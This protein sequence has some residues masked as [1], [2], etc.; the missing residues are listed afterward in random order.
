MI[1]QQVLLVAVAVTA[2]AGSGTYAGYNMMHDADMP[3]ADMEG[4][5]GMMGSMHGMDHDAMHDDMGGMHDECHSMMD[6]HSHNATA[7]LDSAS[8]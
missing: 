8:P 6:E 4:R 2:L 1:T 3:C 7:H 5:H